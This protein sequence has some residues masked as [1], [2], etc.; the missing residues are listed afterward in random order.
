M[1]IGGAP[2]HLR[3]PK[4]CHTFTFSYIHPSLATCTRFLFIQT[5][6]LS[7]VSNFEKKWER[8]G[9]GGGVRKIKIVETERGRERW[10]R[11]ESIPYSACLLPTPQPSTPPYNFSLGA[12]YKPTIYLHYAPEI[13][14]C[15]FAGKK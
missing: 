7:F 5:T 4:P 9:K 14:I 8:H 13:A 15:H 10:G 6:P 1:C 12:S 11:R 2:R 3:T